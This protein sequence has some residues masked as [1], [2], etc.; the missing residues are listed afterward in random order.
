MKRTLVLCFGFGCVMTA[1]QSSG[2]VLGG[3]VLA[4][5]IAAAVMFILRRSAQPVRAVHTAPG[6]TMEEAATHEG[7]HAALVKAAGGTVLDVRIFPDGSGY[8]EYRMPGKATV[9]DWLALTVAGEVASGTSS[10]C[11]SDHAHRDA[12]LKALPPDKR[13]AAKKAGYD[14]ASNVT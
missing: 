14:R 12:L 4:A 2:T 1:L 6:H 5:C 3:I 10:G 8:T 11:S 9:I 13:S 7:G